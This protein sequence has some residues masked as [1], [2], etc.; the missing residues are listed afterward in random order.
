[1]KDVKRG[2]TPLLKWYPGVGLTL[3]EQQLVQEHWSF[4]DVLHTPGGEPEASA[5]EVR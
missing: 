2:F 5:T 3:E 1:M 4:L